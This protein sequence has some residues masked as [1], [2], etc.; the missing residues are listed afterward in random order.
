MNSSNTH[1]KI[2]NGKPVQGQ[3]KLKSRAFYDCAM[4]L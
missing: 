1:K 2:Y 3:P 4:Q